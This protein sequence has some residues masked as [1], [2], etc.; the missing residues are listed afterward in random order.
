M[1]RTPGTIIASRQWDAHTRFYVAN[2]PGDGGKDWGY[3]THWDE[4]LPLNRYWAR[5]FAANCRRINA[6]ANLLTLA[7]AQEQDQIIGASHASL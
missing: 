5:R 1:Q 3:T 2:V 6:S 7:P 4:A